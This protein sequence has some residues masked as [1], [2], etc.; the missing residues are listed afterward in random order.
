MRCCQYLH[1]N[2]YLPAAL[3]VQVF[4]RNEHGY[5]FKFC[6]FRKLW[7]ALTGDVLHSF[8][9]KHIVRACA[10]SEVREVPHI[11]FLLQSFTISP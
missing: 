2:S 3:Y 1:L 9:H 8:D 5:N 7:D 6:I 11:N 4:A 10:F